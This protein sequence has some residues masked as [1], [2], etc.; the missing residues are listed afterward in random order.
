M[1]SYNKLKIYISFYRNITSLFLRLT[2]E[3]HLL[4][5]GQLRAGYSQSEE[6]IKTEID[7]MLRDLDLLKK[8]HSLPKDLSGGMQRKLSI[9]VAFIGGSK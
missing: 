2:V 1:K 3:E 4:F 8:R 9:S 6:A 7:N 5:Y